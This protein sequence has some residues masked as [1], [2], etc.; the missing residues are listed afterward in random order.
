MIAGFK[1]SK[2][3]NMVEHHLRER[4]KKMP[5]SR[6]GPIRLAIRQ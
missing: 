2:E 3:D 5:P 1:A 6:N 4:P